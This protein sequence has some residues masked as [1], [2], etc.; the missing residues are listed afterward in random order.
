MR[1][2][3]MM[4]WKIPPPN[5]RVM[6][7]ARTLAAAGHEVHFLIEG[8]P[9]DAIVETIED[10]Q[11]VRGVRMGRLRE[12]W[13]RYTF[14]FTYREPLWTKAIRYFAE[15]RRIDVLH[16][17]DLPLAR[18]AVFAGRLLKVPVIADLHENYPAGL[19]VWYTNP[20]KKATI[21]N[22]ARWSRYERE[23][24][25]EVDAVI[26]V[27]E[28]ARDRLIALGIPADKIIVVPNTVPAQTGTVRIDEAVLA[29]YRGSF[30]ISYIGGFAPHR[31]LDTVVRALPLVRDRM[32]NARLLLVGGGN[33][34]YRRHLESLA[35][36]L[37]C[38]DL[39]EMAGWQ[40]QEAIWSY[41]E[42][43][44]VCLV[45]HSRNP[46]TDT[47]IPNKIFQYMMRER[48]VIVSDCP[49]LARIVRDTGGGLVFR[50]GDPADLAA[51]IIELH[52]DD[53]TRRAMGVEGRRAV[54]DRYTWEQTSRPLIDLYRTLAAVKNA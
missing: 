8:R 25:R 39:V 4:K 51:R 42:A 38:A 29:R 49:P 14:N 9:G 15:G 41:I 44:A 40:R 5:V 32:P 28:E 35:R 16:V 20:L 43:S 50:A 47:T 54:L 11:V 10:V 17:N 52:A 26:V 24:L 33:E 48:P 53:G 18:E 31:G 12:I 21:Y 1:I 45:P 36:K 19:Q 46:H 22:Y 6:N 30:V 2:G 7:E 37:R 13:H 27:I 3:M 34:G 23:I